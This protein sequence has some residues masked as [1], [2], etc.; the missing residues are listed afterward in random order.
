MVVMT[1]YDLTWSRQRVCGRASPK[2]TTGSNA[3]HP[4]CG[5]RRNCGLLRRLSRRRRTGHPHRMHNLNAA[6]MT[7]ILAHRH[8][9]EGHQ[10]GPTPARRWRGCAAPFR[11]STRWRAWARSGCGGCCT[12]KPYVPALGALTGNQA[13]QQVQAG[14]KAIYLSGWQVA[15]DANNCRPDVSGPESVSG[16][17]RAHCGASRSTTR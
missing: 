15:A 1:S 11:S 14:L 6:E 4:V 10:S 12:T 2:R 8:P 9:L 3:D 7:T 5:R 17:Q 13:V 16:Q